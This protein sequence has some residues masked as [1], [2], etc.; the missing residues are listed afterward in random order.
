MS[1]TEEERKYFEEK[2]KRSKPIKLIVGL[3]VLLIL[4]F[5]FIPYYVMKLDPNPDYESIDA[6]NFSALIPHSASNNS[7]TDIA[8]A[9]KNIDLSKLRLL[10]V[11]IA[12]SSCKWQS[13]ICYA[14]AEY[15]FVKNKIIYVSDPSKQYV[16]MPEET[17]LS[18]GGDCEDKAI[19]L[20]TLLEA[21][22]IDADIGLTSNHAFVRA[23]L[24]DALWRYKTKGDYVYL[25]PT[26]DSCKFGEVRFQ[27]KEVVGFIE[28]I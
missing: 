15:Y 2:E 16:Q 9:V 22:G 1:L 11:K 5:S 6:L 19:L 20:A 13:D 12:T 18:A 3:F 8:S 4:I 26:C 14:K 24:P 10:A 23:Q 21:I 17:L 7:Y 27:S 25:D 28:L